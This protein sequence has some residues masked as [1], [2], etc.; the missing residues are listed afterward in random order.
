[1]LECCYYM[2][3]AHEVRR[4]TGNPDKRPIMTFSLDLPEDFSLRTRGIQEPDT[5]LCLQAVE[6][7]L[8]RIPP[9]EHSRGARVDFRSLLVLKLSVIPGDPLSAEIGSPFEE[10]FR[11]V[12]Q[13]HLTK[14]PDSQ[15]ARE[16]AEMG[17]DGHM[18]QFR[19]LAVEIAM[20]GEDFFAYD[21]LANK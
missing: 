7:I 17:L 12:A 21:P 13:N 19:N 14:N 6:Q 15:A 8:V 3:Q 2:N 18:Y 5:K 16:V 1:M 9:S 10:T 20:G 4:Y 11:K